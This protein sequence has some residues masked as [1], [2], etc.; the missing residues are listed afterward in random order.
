WGGGKLNATSLL[1]EPLGDDDTRA[2]LV[3][4]LEGD[5]LDA[6]AAGRLV[7]VSG[8][9]P[10]FAEEVVAKLIDD[11]VLHHAEG[12]WHVVAEVGA[13]PL[14]ASLGAL[15]GARLDGLP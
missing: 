12:R 11:G 8:G 4:L 14:P 15:L 7:H 2:L 9:N 3:N 6:P 10:L 13:V 1:L 5:A